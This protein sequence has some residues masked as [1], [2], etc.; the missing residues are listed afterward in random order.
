MGQDF[1]TLLVVSETRK[2][3]SFDAVSVFDIFEPGGEP[4]GL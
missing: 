2:V 4:P 3:S 1:I